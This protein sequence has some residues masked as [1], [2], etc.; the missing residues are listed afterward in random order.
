MKPLLRYL[1]VLT[2]LPIL[3]S[4]TGCTYGTIS[5]IYATSGSD[6]ALTEP[7]VAG[8]ANVVCDYQEEAYLLIEKALE[9]AS[10]VE[11]VVRSQTGMDA[12]EEEPAPPCVAFK[13]H[14]RLWFDAAES[15]N[16]QEYLREEFGSGHDIRN[17]SI[18]MKIDLLDYALNF[19]TLGI[20]NSLTIEFSGELHPRTR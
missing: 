14:E 17:V 8:D 18:E 20:A 10:F 5:R 15:I 4:L 3:M 1:P 12:R 11:G 2:C 13:I 9:A 19:V 6:I 16:V 7:R